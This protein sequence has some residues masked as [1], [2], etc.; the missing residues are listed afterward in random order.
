MHEKDLIQRGF[1]LL[2]NDENEKK[3]F[4]VLK[5]Y[6][7]S[8]LNINYDDFVQ[9]GR[10]AFVNAYC[11][12][13]EKPSNDHDDFDLYAYKRIQWR[14]LDLLKQ[15]TALNSHSDFSLDNELIS[16][17]VIEEI[18]IDPHSSEDIGT[19]VLKDDFF[20]QL[21]KT[22]T[23]Q[24]QFYLVSAFAKGM[25]GREIADFYGVTRQ[26]VNKWKKGAI[27]KAK[28]LSKLD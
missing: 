5:H 25:N 18:L 20:K 10:L 24:Q 27:E 28:L 2:G 13:A 11:Q 16:H 17:E 4:G 15:Q 9:E 8:P 6:H 19:Q 7:I 3:I 22:C 21:Y 14:I 12:F 23:Q 1:E 26:A